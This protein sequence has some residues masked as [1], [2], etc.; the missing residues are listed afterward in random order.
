MFQLILPG[1]EG[2]LEVLAG[3]MNLV[4]SL[5]TGL[6]EVKIN[7]NTLPITYVTSSGFADITSI[8]CSVMVENGIELGKVNSAEVDRQLAEIEIN[9]TN[10]KINNL[11]KQ[12]LIEEANFLKLCLGII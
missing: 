7:D 10:E 9:L 1:S 12:Q 11:T 3:H 8:K 5:K 6:L 4:T 2:R